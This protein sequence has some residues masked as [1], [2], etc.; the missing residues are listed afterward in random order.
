VRAPFQV[1]VFPYRAAGTVFEFALFRRSDA[2]YWQGIAGG[3]EDD[4]SP[5][6]AAMR[7]TEEEAGIPR[8]SQF[9]ELDTV[10]SVPVTCFAASAAW[11]DEVYVIPLYTFGVQ[12]DDAPISLSSEH[13]EFEWFAIDTAMD[14]VRY[15]SDRTALWELNQRLLGRGPRGSSDGTSS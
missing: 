13:S 3:G 9:I 2:G 12:A 5:L 14:R 7:E 10:S 11:G 1:V 4:E 6:Q 8:D 15:D